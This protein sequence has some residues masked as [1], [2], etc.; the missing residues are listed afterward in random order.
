MGFFDDYFDP[1]QYNVSG[2]LTGLLESLQQQ[3]GFQPGA[4]GGWP[5]SGPAVNSTM[6]RSMGQQ[7]ALQAAP[8]MSVSQSTASPV[9]SVPIPS[10]RPVDIPSGSIPIG[11][12]LMPQFGGPQASQY[13]QAQPDL[14]DRLG[15]GFKSWAYTPLGN[16]FAALANAITGFNS[17]QF[18]VAP[19]P[20]PLYPQMRQ[21]LQSYEDDTTIPAPIAP[22]R[23]QP[24]TRILTRRN[25][26]PR[27]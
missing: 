1:P 10:P 18:A 2:G 5:Q 27:R 3:Q 7:P 19:T 11:N 6:E 20:K 26:A 16:P 12:Y 9:G 24:A 25:L 22:G 4:F 14:G 23:M 13:F 8:Q 21:A 17:G 15:A